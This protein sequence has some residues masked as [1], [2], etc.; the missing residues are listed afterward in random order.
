MR[1]LDVGN[2]VII[3]FGKTKSVSLSVTESVLKVTSFLPLRV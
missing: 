3:I 2:P 1:A